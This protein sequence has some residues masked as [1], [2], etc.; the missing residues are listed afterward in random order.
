MKFAAIHQIAAGFAKGDAISLE[1]VAIRDL[2]RDLGVASEIYVP[3]ERIAPDCRTAARALEDYRPGAGELLIF[4]YSI[5]SP[6]TEAFR[7][8]PARKVVV[9]H[10]VTP[11]DLFRA[12]DEPLAARLEAARGELAEV[13]RAADAVWADS[14]FNAAEVAALGLGGVRVFPLLFSAAA[15][16]VAPDPVVRQ[17]LSGPSKKILFVGRMAPNKCVE[18]LIEAFAWYHKRLERRSELILVGSER[19]CPRYF[20][21]LRMFAAELDL[22]A[23]SFVRYASPAGLVAYYE[24]ADLFA[25]ASRHEGF[26]LPVVEAM[27]KGVPVLARNVGGVPEAMDGAGVLF[28]G[29]SP[30][31]LACLMHRLISDSALRGEVL[32]SQQARIRRLQARPVRQEFEALLA[33]L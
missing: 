6:A 12:F 28:D 26:C 8:S 30:A 25:T 5:Q 18:E 32:A 21:M 19:A 22:M 14:A 29:A 27:S 1:A 10:N 23:V 24:A 33:A 15:F 4:H 9:Y 20:A 2:C 3:A 13:A 7:R 31:E 16:D 17:G 11:G